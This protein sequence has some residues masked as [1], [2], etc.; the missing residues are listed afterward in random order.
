MRCAKVVR[1]CV[2]MHEGGRDACLHFS[3][4][5][6]RSSLCVARLFKFVFLHTPLDSP[7]LLDYSFD[8]RYAPRT[9]THTRPHTRTHT[10]ILARTHLYARTHM[11][12]RIPRPDFSPRAR[13][14]GMVTTSAS[15]SASLGRAGADRCGDGEGR[16]GRAVRARERRG[17]HRPQLCPVPVRHH[18]YGSR[19]TGPTGKPRESNRSCVGSDACMRITCM[20]PSLS[21][22]HA[23]SWL[24]FC[25]GLVFVFVMF[26]TTKRC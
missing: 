4:F 20:R 6:H 16:C 5:V 14:H 11:P 25:I 7:A 22:K 2:C 3:W 12:A 9:H 23:A 1:M 17:L 19:P 15:A 13:A 18:R 21:A 10:H 8:H 24:L 26:S